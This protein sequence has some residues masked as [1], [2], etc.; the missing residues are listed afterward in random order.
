L[1]CLKNSFSN[2]DFRPDQ[3]KI[4][5]C[6]VIKGA[7]LEKLYKRGKYKLYT[8]EQLINLL[9]KFK[10]M[11]PHYCRIMRI[12]REIPPDFLVAGTLRIDLRKVV[13]DKMRELGLKCNCI[14]CR[15]IGFALLQGDKINKKLHLDI[16]KYTASKGREFFIE[17]V[18][19]DDIIFGLIRL[20]IPNKSKTLLVRE[21]HVYGP[22]IEIG[23]KGKQSQH[24]GLGKWLM[25]EAEKIAKKEKC[26][27]I[28]VISSV[29]VR[30]YYRKLGY[31]L[32][33]PYMVK[34]I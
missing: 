24:I 3:L 22:A 25:D 33:G 26:K 15:E 2:P 17:I 1:R 19:E 27:K 13:H 18:N 29:G 11:V 12:M 6:Q 21:L 4:Y 16:T 23:K 32:E 9:I 20:R 31:E 10:Q 28:S 5:P 14:R 7:E 34:N 30:E 8:K